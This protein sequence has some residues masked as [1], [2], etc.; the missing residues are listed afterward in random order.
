MSD[1]G[2]R[3][4]F[5]THLPEGMWTTVETGSTSQGVP[6]TH[7]LFTYSRSGWIEFKLTKANAVVIRPHQIAFAERYWRL[8]GRCFFAV[9]K[10]R[11]QTKRLSACDELHLFTGDRGR[12]LLAHGL[13]AGI[14]LGIWSGG[15]AKWNWSAVQTF[16]TA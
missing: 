4:L 6:D 2:L 1:G 12:P 11:P 7:F 3:A 14:S 15:P 13:K 5:R 16:L 8:G 9:R 10:K